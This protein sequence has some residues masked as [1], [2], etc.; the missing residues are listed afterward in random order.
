MTIDEDHSMYLMYTTN[1]D[2]IWLECGCGHS[3]HL[4]VFPTPA[5][6]AAAAVLPHFAVLDVQEVSPR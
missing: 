5:D 4:G 3:R 2:G 1:D 6:V